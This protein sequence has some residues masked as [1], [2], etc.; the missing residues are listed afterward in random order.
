MRDFEFAPAGMSIIY[1]CAS[2]LLLYI[3]IYQRRLR[4]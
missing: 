4:L 1:A 2:P 3:Y